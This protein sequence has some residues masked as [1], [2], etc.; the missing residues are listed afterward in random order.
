M[1][2][3]EFIE[4]FKQQEEKPK[5]TTRFIEQY[6]Q[7][8]SGKGTY[9]HETILCGK[10]IYKGEGEPNQK[11][12]LLNAWYQNREE[13]IAEKSVTEWCGLQCPELLLWIA[14]VSGQKE[15]VKDIVNVILEDNDNVYEAND[16]NARR[17]MIQLIKSEIKWTDIE[18]FIKNHKS[19]C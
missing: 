14:E 17:K 1:I 19:D 5:N 4:Y 10:M 11:W 18:D 15:K 7:I 6:Q 2:Y 9:L 12:H 13:T 3:R 16:R 8:N